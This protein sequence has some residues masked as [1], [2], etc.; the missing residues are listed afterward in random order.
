MQFVKPTPFKEAID[1]LDQKTVIASG[2]NSE[3]WSAMPLALK[4]RGFWSSQIESVRF[5]QRGRNSIADFL[6][7]SRETLED[8]RTVLKTGSR[9]DFIKQMQ[10]FAIAEGM[11]PLDP[12]DAGT[13]KD[14]RSERRLG[15][16]F[17]VQTRQADDHGYWKQGMNPDVL[18]A[19]PAQRFIRESAVKEPREFH[20]LH[21]NEVRLKSDVGFWI[22][23]NKD[24]KVPWG[25][26]GWGCGHGVEDVDRTE[27]ERIG[28][29]KPDDQVTSPELDFNERLQASVKQLD[30]DMKDLLKDAFGDQV[31]FEDDAVWWK[32][33]RKGK[34]MAVPKKQAPA[35]PEPQVNETAFPKSLDHLEHVRALGGSTGA[36]LVRD[37]HSGGMFVM[38]KGNNAA[39]IREEFAADELYR[40]M[41]APVPEAKLYEGPGRPTKLARFIEGKNLKDALQEADK[42]QKKTILSK[43]QEHF[44]ADA[45]LS[46][47]DVAG[48]NLDNILVDKH[49]TPWRID[50]GGSLRFRAQGTKKTEAQWSHYPTEIWSLRDPAQNQQTA[51][52]FEG[53]D[54]YSVAR[55]IEKVDTAK[56]IAAAPQ[57]VKQSLEQRLTH[58]KDI[59]AKALEFEGA[60]FVAN[61]A[62]EVTKHVISMRKADTFS[63]M[64]DELIQSHPGDIRPLDKNGNA[65]DLLRTSKEKAQA[66]PS[67][68]FY[69]DVLGAAKT[70]NHH[71]T[72]G[73]TNY[74]AAK[75]AKVGAQKAALNA[76]LANGSATEKAMAAHYLQ[77]IKSIE[78]A[79]GDTK[80]QVPV[81]TK[82]M[83]KAD[84]KTTKGQSIVSKIASYMAENGGNW[85]IIEQWAASQ[86]GSSKS[87]SSKAFKY[88]LMNRLNIEPSAFYDPPDQSSYTLLK[89]SH[90]DKLDRTFE[91]YHGAIQEILSKVKFTGN[92][93]AAKLIRVLRT[94]STTTAVPFKKGT[95][96][97]YKRGVNESASIFAPI[98]KGTRTVT[99]VPH[100]RITGLYFLERKPGTGQTF[101][102]GDN[103]NEVTYIAEGYKAKNLGVQGDVN[104]SPGN[105]HTKWEIK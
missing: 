19:F 30:P 82:F 96:G 10:D 95:A 53:L 99:V 105:D 85:D 94:E 51:K 5:L 100:A 15:L 25:P 62:D 101:F 41:G 55:Q 7:G 52:V 93:Q 65:F 98:F 81:V 6:Q 87:P 103:E 86:G 46:N 71:H 90:G 61:H 13:I 76:L 9:A 59:S 32:G 68:A 17:D 44:A 97:E 45:L 48:L 80:A 58:A 56:V 102:L 29:L 1:K 66:D 31:K 92:D 64:A 2:L 63:G 21:E 37:P 50:N 38:K 70:I 79:Q 20:H 3:Q 77:S 49:G 27:A 33:D 16:I 28:L 36:T 42:E 12:E 60:K 18:A 24:F 67:E 69:S 47:W 83:I 23:L 78:A 26:W 54:I 14:I 73:D 91:I 22:A 8:G 43:V 84:P 11:G 89:K 57:E 4:E 34:G 40:A 72:Q 35:K 88:W 39:H 104:L 75:I 74:N